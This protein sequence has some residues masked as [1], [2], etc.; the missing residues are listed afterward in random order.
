MTRPRTRPAASAAMMYRVT[1]HLHQGRGVRV[2]G[3]DIRATV[4]MGLAELDADTPLVEEL[5][6]AVYAGDWP[7]AYAIGDRLS[8]DVTIA[9]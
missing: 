1:D 2:P 5:V 4:S 9:A 6:C 8:V 3:G 7:T